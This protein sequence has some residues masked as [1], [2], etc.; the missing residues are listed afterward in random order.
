M[1]T[2]T[3]FNTALKEFSLEEL[4]EN[5]HLH[6]GTVRRWKKEN[7][8][9]HS[10]QADFLRM[11]NIE[12]EIPGEREK[13]QF[14]TKP[15]VAEK[16][17]GE[18]EKC[19]KDLGIRSDEYCFVEPS[20]GCGCFYNLL[21]PERKIGIDIDPKT[22]GVIK[23]DYLKWKP[24]KNKKIIV[25]GNP[26]FGL[27]GN[28]ALQFINHSYDF[29][30]VV[31]FILPQLFE[32]DGK[33]SAM[34][35]VRG[36]RLAYSRK[37]PS[38]SFR[39]PDGSDVSINTIF[40]IWTKVNTDRIPEKRTETCDTFV[41]IYSLSDGGMP[42]NTRNK[43]MLDTCDIYLP[44]TTFQKV[45]AYNSFEELPHRRGYGVV[46][47]RRK[48]EIGK[49][50]RRHDWENTAFFSTNSALNLRMSLIKKVVTEAGF[51]D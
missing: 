48:R 25:I 7:R 18:F 29:S 11:L 40:Q 43:K 21:P 36:Y 41:R 14:Y 45:R 38:D 46:I 4:A 30:D 51:V 13:D 49:L 34:K 31:A 35:R 47:H 33:G 24:P 3:L 10:Y 2:L 5:L 42:S 8:V 39:Y 20:A 27:R 19:M 16:C 1:T 50:L 44:S 12:R 32:S 15:E 26:P 37:L 28:L 23:Y 9:P 6:V 22:E 17:F